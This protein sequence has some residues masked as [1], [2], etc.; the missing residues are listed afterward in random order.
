[1]L[2]WTIHL[3]SFKKIFFI[4]PRRSWEQVCI[5]LCGRRGLGGCKGL[6][7]SQKNL[8]NCRQSVINTSTTKYISHPAILNQNIEIPTHCW[9]H[10]ECYFRMMNYQRNYVYSFTFDSMITIGLSVALGTCLVCLFGRYK[11]C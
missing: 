4:K 7:R 1:M 6:A 10:H 8:I 5:L 11:A 2:R 9:N 3:F